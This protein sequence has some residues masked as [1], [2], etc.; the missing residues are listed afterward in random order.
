MAPTSSGQQNGSGH[1][2]RNIGF[3]DFDPK[4]R[5]NWAV[6]HGIGAQMVAS[7]AQG[8]SGRRV[9]IVAVLSVLLIW[10][11]LYIA[12]QRW[13]ASYRERAA[14]GASHVAAALGPLNDIVPPDVDPG[15]WR[16]A[17]ERTR[18]MLTTVA[19]SNLLDR[20]DI[21]N[22]CLELDQFVSKA[23]AHPET[24]RDELATI[25]N[26]MADRAEFL[27]Q[28]SRSPTRDRHVRPR[29]L[30]PRPVKASARPGT[31]SK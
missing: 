26:Q 7:A 12:F 22:L 19:A 29:I 23:R 24:A 30:P 21:D 11:G 17:V 28:D 9:V 2:W 6:A 16:D 8:H 5:G 1:P 27:F 10:G 14:Y 3:D 31:A 20:G 25:W 15:A 4:L 13:R 18:D